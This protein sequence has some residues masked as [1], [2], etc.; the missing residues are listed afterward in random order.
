MSYCIDAGVPRTA[1][2]AADASRQSRERLREASYYHRRASEHQRM[3]EHATPPAA[4]VHRQ[5]VAAYIIAAT[6]VE[7]GEA[8]DCAGWHRGECREALPPAVLESLLAA[9]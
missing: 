2:E 1:S 5:L 6:A 3:A 9:E 4:A 8:V 7:R